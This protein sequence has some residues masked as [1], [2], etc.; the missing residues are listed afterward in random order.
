VKVRFVSAAAF[1][2][3]EAIAYYYDSVAMALGER[4]RADV[5]ALKRLWSE[6]SRIRLLTR[7]FVPS[8][9]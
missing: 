7:V 4:L 1:E 8:D 3:S 5:E 2:L 9:R 6:S